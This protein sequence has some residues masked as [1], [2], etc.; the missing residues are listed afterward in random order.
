MIITNYYHYNTLYFH[1]YELCRIRDPEFKVYLTNT[2]TK[3][4]QLKQIYM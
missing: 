3:D 4:K 2:H 1:H